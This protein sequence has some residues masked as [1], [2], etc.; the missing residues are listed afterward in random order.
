MFVNT[1]NFPYRIKV[2]DFGNAI[3]LNEVGQYKILQTLFYRSPE[4]LLGA[5]F[6]HAIDVWSVGCI[7]AELYLGC[8]LFKGYSAYDQIRL[9]CQTQG[10]PEKE[11]LIAG[12]Y[13][14]N[15][16]NRYGPSFWT[17]KSRE[18]YTMETNRI[19]GDGCR[20]KLNSLEDVLNVRSFKDPI[21]LTTALDDKYEFV[22]LLKLLLAVNQ[23]S[24]ISP[25]A[26]VDH[27]FITMKDIVQ[28]YDSCSYAK[29]S[30]HIMKNL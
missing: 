19:S 7:A 27:N 6:G 25:K 21:W 5:P 23:S 24:R 11:I 1:S 28:F 17:L 13:T 8:I 12:T 4:V 2:V 16:F 14:S 26:A 18:Q 20:Y 15:Y 30:V 10:L 29:D 22:N 9:I 3:S